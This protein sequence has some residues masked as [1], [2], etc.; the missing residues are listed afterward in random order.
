MEL[1]DKG[2]VNSAHDISEG[3]L[4]IAVLESCFNPEQLFGAKL[5][6]DLELNPAKIYFGEAAGRILISAAKDKYNSIKEAAMKHGIEY[7]KIGIVSANSSFIVNNHINED[8][9][10]LH[11]AWKQ[12]II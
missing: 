10:I 5:S 7:H 2:L 1:I 4:L 9:A 6:F 8:M 11:S 12:G 3:G